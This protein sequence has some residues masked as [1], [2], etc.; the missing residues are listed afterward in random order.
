M[1]SP[2]PDPFLNEWQRRVLVWFLVCFAVLAPIG[3]LFARRLAAPLRDFA[4]AAERLGYYRRDPL[5][6]IPP[7]RGPAEIGPAARAFNTMHVRL[8]R[9]VEDRTAMVG[10]ISHDLRTPLTRI[11]FK[12]EGAP[13]ALRQSIGQDIRQM[14]D[15]ISSVLHFIR[16]A[17]EP[18]PR[19]LVDLRSL[20]QSAVDDCAMTGRD[21]T[22]NPDG[23]S[24]VVEVEVGG[25]AA[26][27]QQSGGER[28]QVRRPAL[29]VALGERGWRADRG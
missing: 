21:A 25:H 1:V 19:D 6:D 29:R 28:H 5:G 22:L 3:Y 9:Y 27:V 15:M 16:D 2:A 4:Q 17:A 11:R 20:L 18:G 7:L 14:E 26:A 24:P 12:L 8:K 10:A 13:P 23:P